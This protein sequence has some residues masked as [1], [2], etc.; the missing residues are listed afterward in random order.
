MATTKLRLR[1]VEADSRPL[2]L[3]EDAISIG[4]HPANAIPIADDKA[5][6][7]HCLI[8]ADPE[9]G[10][11]VRDLGSRNGTRLNGI[12]IDR[13]PIAPGDIIQ[14]GDTEF[15]VEES[16]S[17][18][19]AAS[20]GDGETPPWVED[21]EKVLRALEPTDLPSPPIKLLSA[22][23][24]PSS[25]IDTD[26]DAHGPRAVRLCLQVASKARATDLHIEPRTEAVQIRMR[27]DGQM[28]WIGDIPKPVGERFIGLIKNVCQLGASAADAVLDGHFS[29]RFDDRRVE[30]RASLTPTM[31]GSKLVI[32]VLDSRDIPT[33]VTELGLAPYMEDRIRRVCTLSQGMLL[34][35]GPTG[36]GKT[37]TLY[38]CLRAV[39][40]EKKNV[41]TI[42]DPVEY[43]LEGCT[44][45]PIN[46]QRGNTFHSLL[47]SCLRQDPDVILLGE[48]RDD[49]TARTAMQAAMTG[50]L[51]FSTIHAKDTIS[52]VFRLLDLKVEPY[53]V[54]NSLD[55]ILAQ[56]LV[57]VLCNRCQRDVPVSPGQATRIGKYLGGATRIFAPVGCKACLRTG[58]R[59]RKALFELLEFNDDLR[60]VIL[61]DQSIQG[62]RRI[63][64]QGLFTTLLQSGWKLAAAGHT[65]LEEVDAVCGG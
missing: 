1:Q 60:D 58:Y 64:A 43:H 56:R 21:I 36:S 62:M 15:L 17:A 47:R 61:T 13:A 57:R 52:A 20:N 35:C 14:V 39:D 16:I 3:G 8:E 50:H 30:Y 27:V 54:A 19:P 29:A 18:R 23:G 51:V 2:P 37:T 34:V 59:G 26:T 33:S 5:S 12:G 46:E 49:E 38:N 65:S 41:I 25:A 6:R 4:R 11:R 22:D 24:Q 55:L 9:G 45:I 53:L 31:Q 32:R 40:R 10:F 7:K 48:V 42:E 28:V 44:Q 63:I